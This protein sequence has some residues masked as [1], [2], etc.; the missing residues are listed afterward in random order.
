ME[1]REKF[2]AT[3]NDIQSHQGVIARLKRVADGTPKILNIT[4]LSSSGQMEMI[5]VNDFVTPLSDDILKALTTAI[6]EAID[7]HQ[8][9]IPS[10][11]SSIGIQVTETIDP[12]KD[13]IKKILPS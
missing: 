2:Y 9:S 8:N 7:F 12:I 1:T 11:E 13:P 5:S 10:L 3:V 4:F 6:N